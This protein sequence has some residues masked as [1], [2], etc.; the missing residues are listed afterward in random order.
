[1]GDMDGMSEGKENERVWFISSVP[2]HVAGHLFDNDCS[3]AVMANLL[4]CVDATL[5][6]LEIP[7]TPL[8]WCLYSYFVSATNHF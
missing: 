3:L 8:L 7:L 6:A 5:H 2:C 4:G 1:M